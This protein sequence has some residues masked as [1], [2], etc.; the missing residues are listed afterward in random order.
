M[1]VS[2]ELVSIIRTSPVVQKSPKAEDLLLWAAN[3]LDM[4]KVSSQQ[5]LTKWLRDVITEQ[6]KEIGVSPREYAKRFKG[7]VKFFTNP[8]LGLTAVKHVQDEMLEEWVQEI[9]TTMRSAKDVEDLYR[10]YLYF[11]Q[12]QAPP[13]A[14]ANYQYAYKGAFDKL[15]ALIARVARAPEYKE[16]VKAIKDAKQVVQNEQYKRMTSWQ[17]RKLLDE[18][19]QARELSEELQ[20]KLKYPYTINRKTISRLSSVLRKA[21]ASKKIARARPLRRVRRRLL[22]W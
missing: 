7:M 17:L 4:T 13:L 8:S 1:A 15:K 16:I 5:D 20:K 14:S 6:A 3:K 9:D 10:T 18:L 21:L 2:R 19:Q 11:K 12:R 22:R